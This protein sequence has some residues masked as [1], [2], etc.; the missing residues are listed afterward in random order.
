MSLEQ[1]RALFRLYFKE[2]R[3]IGPLGLIIPELREDYNAHSDLIDGKL[4]MNRI[5]CK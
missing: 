4:V 5:K 1:E 2:K 3:F